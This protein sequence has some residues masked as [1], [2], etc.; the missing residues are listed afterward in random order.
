MFIT[1]ALILIALWL[2]NILKDVLLPFCVATLIAYMLEPIVQFNRRLLRLKGRLIAIILTL[3][4]IIVVFGGLSWLFVPM[5]IH[6][7]EQMA[8]MLA[9]Y[10]T[11]EFNVPYIP[12]AVHDFVVKNIDFNHFS[13]LLAKIDVAKICQNVV[14]GVWGFLST[15]LSFVL[16]LLSWAIV[17]LYVVFIMLDYDR[18][19]NLFHD[20]VPPRWRS[21]CFTIGHDVK[22]SMNNYFRGQ[23][24]V[25]FIVGIL[26]CIG[27]MIVGLP[28]AIVMGLFIGVLNM[29]PYLQLIS[30]VPTGFLCIVYSVSNGVA[31]WPFFG[32]VFLVYCV[33][34]VIQDLYLTPKIMGKAMGLNPAIILLSLSIWGTLL[35]FLGMIIAL[36][37]TTLCLSY[38]SRYVIKGNSLRKNYYPEQTEETEDITPK[39]E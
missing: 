9:A 2:L 38:Y 24:L 32:K 39:N 29:V 5:M 33:V 37:L 8:G 14:T 35:G 16:S 12:E 36:P 3:I 7:I 18:L 26:F 30:F 20:M 23:A 17:V 27:F 31:F 4:E 1:I 19:Y 13:N 11:A 15:S 34:Q 22:T 21:V 28:M 25:S 6:E 10:A